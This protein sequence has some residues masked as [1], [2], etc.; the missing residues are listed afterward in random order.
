MTLLLALANEEYSLI[1]GDRRLTCNGQICEDEANKVCVLFCDDARLAIAFTGIATVHRFRTQDWLRGTLAEISETTHTLEKILA[2]LQSRANG[3]LSDGALAKLSTAGRRLA[4]LIS[5]FQYAT[6]SSKHIC[7]LLSNFNPDVLTSEAGQTFEF[8][9]LG[10]SGEVIVEAA[11]YTPPMTSED[12]ESLR[13]PLQAKAPAARVLH[14]AVEIIQRISKEQGTRRLIGSQCNS[15]VVP[16]EVDRD[17]VN[18]YHSARPVSTVYG[19]DVVVAVTGSGGCATRMRM[20]T[21]GVILAGP[22]I[23]KNQECWCGS[24]EKFGK[25]HLKKYGS[26]YARLPGFRRPMAMMFAIWRT[27]PVLSGRIYSVR[28]AFS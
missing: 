1:L 14:K 7:Y 19:P 6:T 24:G 25:C 2:E 12:Y 28:S 8:Y 5:G 3:L 21:E 10:K 13:E 17:I 27:E 16:R 20:G 26:T 22:D 9:Q 11:G 18:T 4:F 15:A 23:R